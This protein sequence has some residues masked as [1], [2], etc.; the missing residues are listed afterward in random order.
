MR[1]V[2]F[3]QCNVVRLLKCVIPCS[4]DA[5]GYIGE[6]EGGLDCPVC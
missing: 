1:Y 2:L 6:R 4:P 3:L 5:M